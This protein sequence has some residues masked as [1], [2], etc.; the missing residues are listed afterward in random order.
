MGSNLNQPIIKRSDAERLS[1]TRYFTGKPCKRGHITERTY[2]KSECV[3][4]RKEYM[5]AYYEENK[6]EIEKYKE[7]WRLA[8]P[9]KVKTYVKTTKSNC[10]GRVNHD[11]RMRQLK[12]RNATPPWA[13]TKEIRKL[14]EKAVELSRTTGVPHDVDHIEPICGKDVSGLH[15]HFN[16]QVIP[17]RLNQIKGN[18]RGVH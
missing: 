9:E 4:C 2:P 7:E 16:L 13:D 6:E 1:L 12:L 18:R 3:Q 17:S 8:H 14:Y 5:L 15:V 11:T 10:K